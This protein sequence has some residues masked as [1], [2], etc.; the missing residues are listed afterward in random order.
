MPQSSAFPRSSARRRTSPGGRGGSRRRRRARCRRVTAVRSYD[1]TATSGPRSAR[2]A[3]VSWVMSLPVQVGWGSV[4][5]DE[6]VGRGAG[7]GDEV[8]VG[9]VGL[10]RPAVRRVG[11]LAV[12]HV[13]L[14][15]PPQPGGVVSLDVPRLVEQ[16]PH[17]SIVDGCRLARAETFVYDHAD[18]DHLDGVAPGRGARIADRDRR[19]CS[20]DGDIAPLEEIVELGLRFD[21][22]VMVDEAHGTGTL[23]PEGRGAVADAGLENEVDVI[24][25]TLGK[26]LGSYGAF[27][28]CERA[29]AKYL[30]NTA[31]TLIFSTALPP[32]AVAA[33]MAAL[34]LLREQPRRVEKLHRN[35]DVLREA[36]AA[37]DFRRGLGD[38]DRPAG[39]RGCRGAV[40]AS[41]RALEMG[42]FAQAIR[43]PTVPADTSRL[44]LA[45]MASH[46]NT[47]L[48]EPRPRWPPRCPR[49]CATAARRTS[50]SGSLRRVRRPARRGLIRACA[51]SSSPART[52]G[53]ASRW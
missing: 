14:H 31:R 44:R 29:M 3:L 12:V 27:V 32:P 34:R 35:A 41:E 26:A 23:G 24:V 46:T 33:A 11:G 16:R 20:M 51:G 43:P 18:P 1:G 40:R 47:E 37:Q 36:L 2:C 10:G 22:R 45:V 19:W 53:W 7:P 30:V 21:A 42:V 17:A 9:L 39:D 28:C 49:R 4:D 38:P 8:G 13:S 5:R 15:E 52:P 50:G 48:R 6:Q 25:G